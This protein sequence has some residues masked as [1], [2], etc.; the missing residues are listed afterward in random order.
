[1]FCT[2]L[3]FIFYTFFCFISLR[4]ILRFPSRL[5][6]ID[7][8]INYRGFYF[9]TSNIFYTLS[10]YGHL[11]VSGNKKTKLIKAKNFICSQQSMYGIVFF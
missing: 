3:K 1:M 10:N 9:S 5:N 6:L 11:V 7:S 8:Q 4:Q 2:S